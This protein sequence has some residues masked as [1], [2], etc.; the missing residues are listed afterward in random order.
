MFFDKTIKI[1]LAISL[2]T[3]AIVFLK[4]SNLN[5]F[6]LRRPQTQVEITYVQQ[7]LKNLPSQSY[8][9][10]L[11]QTPSQQTSSKRVAPPPYVQNDLLLKK[12]RDISVEKPDFVKP[13]I[14]AMKK[15]VTLPILDQE[16][17]TNPAYLSYYQLVR[18]KIK[19]MAYQN[20]TRLFNGEVYLSF[21]ILHNGQLKDVRINESGST[22]HTYLKSVAHKSIRDASPFPSF[23]AELDYPELSFNVIISF[24][25]E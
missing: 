20:Y 17:I 25:I 16:K 15:K 14:I 22:T 10:K 9:Q 24:E 18:E 7:E 3:H 1:A 13:E 4:F 12:A 11:P 2:A 6:A 19:N 5:I 23:P 21:I 8:A